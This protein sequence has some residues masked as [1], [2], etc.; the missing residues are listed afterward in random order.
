MAHITEGDILSNQISIFT[1]QWLQ[2]RSEQLQ[3]LIRMCD[4]NVITVEPVQVDSELIRSQDRSEELDDLL[5]NCRVSLA[6]HYEL[7][8]G[9]GTS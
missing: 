6:P 3:N 9:S 4:V 7:M 1:C 8:G 2:K 5:S